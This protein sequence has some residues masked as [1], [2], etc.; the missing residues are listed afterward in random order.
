MYVPVCVALR[1]INT[2]VVAL[3]IAL[4]HLARVERRDVRVPQH[5]PLPQ[6]RVALQ[7]VLVPGHLQQQALRL[8][9]VPC[10]CSEGSE[11]LLSSWAVPCWV[12][13]QPR[14]LLK[15]RPPDGLRGVRG[16]DDVDGLAPE[17]IEHLPGRPAEAAHQ[18]LERLVD[19]GLGGGGGL[20]GEA[21]APPP[22]RLRLV[23]VR[24]LNLLGDVGQVE[25]V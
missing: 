9:V 16:E 3:A 20:V 8:R 7:Q 2:T 21:A 15:Q 23:A 5:Q 6:V 1:S 22:A 25:H 10:R 13:D 11:A 19:V 24:H 14:V 12:I 4:F 17:R 18:A